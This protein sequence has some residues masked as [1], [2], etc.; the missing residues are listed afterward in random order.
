MFCR[1]IYPTGKTS[2]DQHRNTTY[3]GLCWFFQQSTGVSML[4]ASSGPEDLFLP[5]VQ[6]SWARGA[7]IAIKRWKYKIWKQETHELM[8]FICRKSRAQLIGTRTRSEYERWISYYVTVTSR[9]GSVVPSVNMFS[10]CSSKLSL[11]TVNRNII[12]SLLSSSSC[13]SLRTFEHLRLV[14]RCSHTSC[15]C[16]CW[17]ARNP[18]VKKR[19][20]GCTLLLILHQ[21]MN[22]F[23][24]FSFRTSSAAHLASDYMSCYIINLKSCT[25]GKRLGRRGVVTEPD[26][27]HTHTHTHTHTQRWVSSV[28][29]FLWRHLISILCCWSFSQKPGAAGTRL[30]DDVGVFSRCFTGVLS[31]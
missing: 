11:L 28:I 18:A 5:A 3:A 8:S 16:E 6:R 4:T 14:R 17:A 25:A 31:I 12:F 1:D 7:N 10:I 2:I 26:N 15:V 9:W 24:N 23:L 29:L 19:R 22:E 13:C 21:W 20:W 30:D 27:L